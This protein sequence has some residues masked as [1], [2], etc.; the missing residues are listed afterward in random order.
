MEFDWDP[1][2]A[3]ANELKHGVT[4]EE[5]STVFGDPLAA[6]IPDPDHSAVGVPVAALVDATFATADDK[7]VVVISA[8]PATQPTSSRTFSRRSS[9]SARELPRA[10]WTSG[11]RPTSSPAG[12]PGQR[13]PS[14]IGPPSDDRGLV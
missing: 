7:T 13:D 14:R 8:E 3:A 11:R 5:A 2:K 10:S 6:T 12:G 4:F 1:E 9:S